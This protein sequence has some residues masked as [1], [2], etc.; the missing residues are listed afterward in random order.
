VKPVLTVATG[1]VLILKKLKI[2][3]TR[4]IIIYEDLQSDNAAYGD[5]E[6]NSIAGRRGHVAAFL[7][8]Q[9]KR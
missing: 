9:G 4:Q 6:H 5:V 3:I 1:W 8:E 2:N 7:V